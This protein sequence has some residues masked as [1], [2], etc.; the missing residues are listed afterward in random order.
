MLKLEWKNIYEK[1]NIEGK[2]KIN[3]NFWTSWGNCNSIHRSRP[4]EEMKEKEVYLVGL[5][6]HSTNDRVL[7]YFFTTKKKTS[8]LKI[9]L[10]TTLIRAESNFTALLWQKKKCYRSLT[11]LSTLQFTCCRLLLT[12]RGAALCVHALLP[13]MTTSWISSSNS[14]AQAVPCGWRC[15]ASHQNVVCASCVQVAN[16]KRVKHK[17]HSLHARIVD[18][19]NWFYIWLSFAQEK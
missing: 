9:N 17:I 1:N 7:R 19:K 10:H 14:S 2:L 16:S 8:T 6:L 12:R 3:N 11:S 18:F 4:A 13:Q 5:D 15:W